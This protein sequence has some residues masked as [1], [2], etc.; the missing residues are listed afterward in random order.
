MPALCQEVAEL[1][2]QGLEIAPFTLAPRITDVTPRAPRKRSA[3]KPKACGLRIIGLHWL[4]AKTEGLQLTSPTRRCARRTADY[5]VE[6]A[7]CTR[8]LGGDLMVFGSPAQAA[9]SRRCAA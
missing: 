8:D 5:L 1:G 3:G 7:R 4:L 9:H 2:Y 6:L